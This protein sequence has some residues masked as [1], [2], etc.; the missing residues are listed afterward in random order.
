MLATSNNL[1][2]RGKERKE[3]ELTLEAI[4][5]IERLAVTPMPDIQGAFLRGL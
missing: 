1:T 2:E 3:E 4:R 5:A